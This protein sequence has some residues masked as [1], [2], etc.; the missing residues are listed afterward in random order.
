MSVQFSDTEYKF[1]HGKAPR[2][3]GNWAF[4]FDSNDR[5]CWFDGKYSDAKRA[6][7]EFAKKHKHSAVKVG[8]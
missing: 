8:S 6:A 7:M 4:F 2:G 1:A 5:P 3:P